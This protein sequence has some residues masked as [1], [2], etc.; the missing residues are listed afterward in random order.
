MAHDFEPAWN[1]LRN[2]P[3]AAGGSFFVTNHLP[4]KQSP[5]PKAMEIVSLG[6]PLENTAI[7][8]ARWIF[9]PR[10]KQGRVFLRI[11]NFGKK[12]ADVQVRGRHGDQQLFAKTLSLN[13]GAT[14]RSKPTFAVDSA[15]WR[16]KRVLPRTDSTL[17]TM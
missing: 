12:P 1:R 15:I 17:T 5:T 14:R 3:K 13:A 16:S 4:P 10:T 2:W 6:Q 9:D 11:A 8:A 7:A